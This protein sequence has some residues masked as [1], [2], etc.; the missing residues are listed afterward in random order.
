MKMLTATAAMLAAA[1]PACA[2]DLTLAPLADLRARYEYVD[3]AGLAQT[4]DALTLRLRGGLVASEG[5]FSALVEGQ[6][7]LGARQPLL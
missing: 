6:G 2:Q 1:G 4:A 3:Q 5:A 7:T